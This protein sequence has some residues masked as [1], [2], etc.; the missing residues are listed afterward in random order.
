MYS[1]NK[2]IWVLANP[3]SLGLLMLA[4]GILL[5][6]ACRCAGGVKK[7]GRVLD[8]IAKYFIIIYLKL[9]KKT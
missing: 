7:Q 8:R 9:N 1:L 2:I 5:K 6:A 3:L 4:V